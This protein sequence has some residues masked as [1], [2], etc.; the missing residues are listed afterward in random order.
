MRIIRLG[1]TDTAIFARCTIPLSVVLCGSYNTSYRPYRHPWSTM[2]PG[3]W[4]SG[5]RKYDGGLFPFLL[6]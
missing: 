2:V 1:S 4:E 5:F 6:C 3:F